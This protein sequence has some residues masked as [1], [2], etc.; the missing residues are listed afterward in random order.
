MIESRQSPTP[1]ENA[2][3]ASTLPGAPVDCLHDRDASF[4]CEGSCTI[5]EGGTGA[6]GWRVASRTCR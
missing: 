1:A 6:L 5:P 3:G 2:T 4:P